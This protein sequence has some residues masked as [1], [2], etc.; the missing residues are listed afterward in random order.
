MQNNYRKKSGRITGIMTKYV[1]PLEDMLFTLKHVVDWAKIKAL[2]GNEEV[3]DE[4]VSAIFDEAAKMA[5]DGLSPLNKEGD[6]SPAVLENGNVKSSPG[7]KEFYKDYRDAGWNTLP[8]PEEFGGQGL[9]WAVS[10]GINEM[11]QSS[12]LAFGLCPLLN[13]GAIDAVE[14]YASEELKEKFLHKMV[15]GEWTGTMN[16]TEPQAGSDLGYIKTKAEKN[17]DGSYKISGQKIYITW[18]DHDMS[19]NIIHLVLARLPDAPEGVK[20]ISLFIVPKFKINDDGTIGNEND[21]KCVGLEHKLGIHGSPTCTMQFGD[22]GGAEGYLVGEENKG[23]MYMFKMMNNARLH[24]GLQGVAVAEMAY[25]KALEYSHERKQGTTTEGEKYA[26][27]AKHAD[28]ARMLMTMKSLTEAGRG[29]AYFAGSQMDIMSKSADQAE[30]DHAMALCDLL[31][32]IVKGWC[33]DLGNEVASLGVQVHGGM[34]FVEETGAAQYLRDARILPI[35]EG[36]NGIQ[37]K[38]LV[39]RKIL[40][41]KAPALKPLLETMTQFADDISSHEPELS[42][43]LK[44]GVE[45]IEK[46]VEWVQARAARGDMASVEAASYA[47]M[48]LMGTVIGG[49]VM[50]RKSEAAKNDPDVSAEFKQEKLEMAQ[51]Y[52]S[53]IYPRAEK[54]YRCILGS[55]LITKTMKSFAP[56]P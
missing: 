49:Y 19:D 8:F 48:N 39:F 24:V 44:D 33:T 3:D 21:V 31:T 10:M 26:E 42:E 14:A 30:Q 40:Q 32:P 36:T 54:E 29:L 20:G 17:A 4:L 34:G 28:V 25:Q 9:P 53:Q 15:S 11:W 41:L 6:N 16:L 56:K 51:F 55:E 5:G 22:E 52:A 13:Q 7:F 46:S 37:A 43:M 45:K 12:N 23:L 50:A 27:I 35:Y 38:D 1:A 2:P 18:G 47:V